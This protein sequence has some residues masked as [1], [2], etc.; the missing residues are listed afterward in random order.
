MPNDVLLIGHSLVGP[1]MPRMLDGLLGAR[2]VYA[3]VI[4]G[5]PLIYNW[6]HGAGAEGVNARAVLPL[7]SYDTLILTEAVPLAGH[8]QWSNTYGVAADYANLAW[9]A[10]SD[11][12][13]LIYETWGEIGNPADWRANLTADR[14]MWMGIVTHLNDLRPD[15][16]PT[17]GL[18]PGGAAMA[19]LYDAIAAGRGLGL[20]N[21]SQIFTDQIHLNDTGNYMIAAL[22]AA[23]I[24]GRS[25]V[26]LT[27]RLFGE[28]GQPYG[29]WTINQTLL[30][31]HIA[32]EAAASAPGAALAPGVIAP[33]LMIGGAGSNLL[34]SGQGDDR[35]YGKGGHDTISGLG[36]RDLLA[37]D[38][39]NDSLFGGGNHD[40][41]LGGTGHDTLLGQGGN[42]RLL[43]Q[44]GDDRL[45]GG[46]GN[47]RLFGGTGADVFVFSAGSGADRIGDFSVAQA[48]RLVFD[49]AMW[50]G[51]RSAAQVVS[52]FASVT[53]QGVLF[54]FTPSNSVLLEGVSTTAGLAGLIDII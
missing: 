40:F 1:T 9:T 35:V 24:T 8:I 3:Q 52:S 18:V 6:D 53:A 10:R 46:L 34:T 47:D 2:S 51:S 26:G 12:R 45:V 17:V 41:L 49:D 42:D 7:G 48:D 37:G 11:A 20:T 28:W 15:D 21:I 16:A 32:W 25:P 23:V 5:A 31:Q 29:G 27:D 38:A 19:R 36:G 50:S 30:L 14:S 39:G 43:G 44:V 13:V 54:Q 4:N 33:R 22:Q